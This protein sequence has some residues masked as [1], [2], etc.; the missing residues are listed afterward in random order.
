MSRL[1]SDVEEHLSRR[2]AVTGRHQKLLITLVIYGHPVHLDDLGQLPNYETGGDTVLSEGRADAFR[3]EQVR[4]SL[5]TPHHQGVG[6][7][8]LDVRWHG[9]PR[10]YTSAV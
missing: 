2:N 1:L 10:S 4:N 6:L 8:L 3:H 7:H 5:L 9:N